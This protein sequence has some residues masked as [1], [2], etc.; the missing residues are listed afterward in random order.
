MNWVF[1]VHPLQP[2]EFKLYSL[3]FLICT[4]RYDIPVPK[5]TQGTNTALS[6]LS[7]SIAPK[8]RINHTVSLKLYI[9]NEIALL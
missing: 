1:T 6:E 7:L 9:K 8:L 2:Y 4:Q 5:N 3:N